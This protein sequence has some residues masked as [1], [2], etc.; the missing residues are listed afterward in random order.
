MLANKPAVVAAG[1]AAAVVV[2]AA[3]FVAVVDIAV[4]ALGV[5]AAPAGF[6]VLSFPSFSSYTTPLPQTQRRWQ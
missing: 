2:A 1:V 6:H 3:A 5:A 4:H